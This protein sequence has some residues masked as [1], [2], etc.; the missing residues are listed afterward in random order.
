MST[1]LIVVIV[2]GS[3]AVVVSFDCSG[4][5]DFIKTRNTFDKYRVKYSTVDLES[6]PCGMGSEPLH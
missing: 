4:R 5:W 3:W 2:V 1:R 6:W